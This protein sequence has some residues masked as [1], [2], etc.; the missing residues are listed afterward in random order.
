MNLVGLNGL[1]PP[2]CR[3]GRVS[4]FFKQGHFPYKWTWFEHDKVRVVIDYHT[5]FKGADYLLVGFSS[6]GTLAFEIAEMDDCCKGLIVH[7]GDWR[8]TE[9]AIECPMLLIATE[10]DRTP[11]NEAM[12]RAFNV[13]SKAGCDVEL[14]VLPSPGLLFRH[15]FR[16]GLP[17]MKEWAQRKLGFEMPV[18]A[19]YL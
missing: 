15:R 11:T 19:K 14:T 16:N 3:Y 4:H 5:K 6:G 7:S 9:H 8:P 18:K 2:L 1:S 10:G 13:Y 12:E 17:A